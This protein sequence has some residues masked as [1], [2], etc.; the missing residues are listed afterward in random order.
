MS[1]NWKKIV[2]AKQAERTARLKTDLTPSRMQRNPNTAG[3]DDSGSET[4]NTSPSSDQKYLLANAKQIV[5][6]IKNGDNDWTSERV[7]IA[8]ARQAIRAQDATNCLTEV[9]FAEALEEA[10]ALD[11]EFE[12]TRVIKGPLHGVPV[13]FKDLYRVKGYDY[14]VGFTT[15]CDKPS[16]EDGELVSQVRAAGGIP[17]VKTNVPQT[18]LAYECRNPVFGRTINPWSSKH[19]SGGSSGGEAALLACDGSPIGFGS[20][21][22]GSLRIPTSYCGIYAIKPGHSRASIRGSRE[23]ASGFEGVR[24]CMG[25]MGRSVDDIELACRLIFGQSTKLDIWLPPLPYKEVTIPVKLK[26]GYYKSDALVRASPAVQRAVQETV[27]ALRRQGHECVEFV[28]PDMIEA[29]RI[30]LGLI[31]AEKFKMMFAHLGQ[32]PKDAS[33]LMASV[34]PVLPAF[35]RHFVAWSVRTFLKDPIMSRLILNFRGRSVHEFVALAGARDEYC[36]R[37]V[38]EVWE[39]YGFDGIIC[40]VQAMPSVPHGAS[41]HA[42]VLP[43]T[44]ALYNV[45]DHPIGVVPVTRVDQAKDQLTKSWEASGNQGSPFIYS[46]LYEGKQPYYDAMAMHGIPVGVQIVGRHW[47]DEKV[48][49]MM[50][51]VDDALGERGFGPGSYSLTSTTKHD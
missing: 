34:A 36:R 13:S 11:R 6:H 49:K 10:R 28:V 22:G 19:T 48:I 23:L 3:G 1:P 46:Q 45:V 41:T 35:L 44:T 14:S 5:E 16:D 29:I 7:L 50:R 2:R 47:E 51:V 8:Y 12:R 25:P 21:I 32:D 31:S 37:F 24:L 38:R 39:A 33:L 43:A 17:F 9:M 42:G 18:M 27:E 4:I 30:F 15:Y 26:F 40:P 20:D